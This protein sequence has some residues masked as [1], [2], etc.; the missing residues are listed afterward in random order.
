MGKMKVQIHVFLTLSS[1]VAG[2][3][4]ASYPG[5]FIREKELP[6]P[7]IFFGEETVWTL[8][9]VWTT[10]KGKS[11]PY[12]DSNSDSSAVHFVAGRYADWLSCLNI[13]RK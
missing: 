1:L 4:A 11:C 2:E 9:L 6:P 13:L 7:R 10:W 5:L 8:K 12:R 3:W